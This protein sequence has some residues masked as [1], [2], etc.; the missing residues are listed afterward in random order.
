MKDTVVEIRRIG[1]VARVRLLSGEMMKIPSAVF[2]ERRVRA[3]QTIDAEAYRLYMKQHAYPHALEVAVNYLALRERSEKEIVSR[4]K[5]SCYDEEVIAR[6]METLLAHGF[7]SDARFAEQW[8]SHR[9]KKYGRGRIMQELKMKGVSDEEAKAALK[10]LPEEDELAAALRQA[11]RISRRL[12]GDP[13]K[14]AQ[15]LARR[16]YAWHLARTAAESV[17][18]REK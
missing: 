10:E 18:G 9:A 17:S 5:R 6:V 4:L 15:A 13:K 1:G 16:G 11:E 3:G 2:L 14:I 7:L 8:V 12:K